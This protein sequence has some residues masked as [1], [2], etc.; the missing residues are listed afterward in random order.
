MPTVHRHWLSKL[1]QR[2]TICSSEIIK[3]PVAKIKWVGGGSEGWIKE[4]PVTPI[5]PG[6]KSNVHK[7]FRRHP[8][9]LLNVLCTFNLC[10][11]STEVKYL[12]F[13]DFSVSRN[14]GRPWKES[15][16]RTFRLTFSLYARSV[17]SMM[18]LL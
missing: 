13:A 6:F 2:L 5:N 8:G 12:H 9:H 14:K 17:L 7:M 4:H 15:Q 10:P 3:L 18:F 11:V 16:T 1:M